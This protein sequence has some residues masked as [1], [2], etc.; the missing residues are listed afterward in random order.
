MA[1]TIGYNPLFVCLMLFDVIGTVAAW[2][3]ISNQ[4]KDN[5]RDHAVSAALRPAHQAKA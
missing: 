1:S 2:R 5:E 3:L 4:H